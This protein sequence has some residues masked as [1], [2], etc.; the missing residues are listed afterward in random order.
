MLIKLE[1][2]SYA[3]IAQKLGKRE[4]TISGWHR[5]IKRKIPEAHFAVSIAKILHTTVEYLVTGEE[6]IVPGLSPEALEIARAADKLNA[7]GKRIILFQTKT[8]EQ[9][10]PLG[11]SESVITAI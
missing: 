5:G 11:I 8:L 1:K 2:T 10:Y 9:M 6:V 7:E 3:Y 4:S